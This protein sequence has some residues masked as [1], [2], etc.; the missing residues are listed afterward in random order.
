MSE[1]RSRSTG[2]AVLRKLEEPRLPAER[3]QETIQ[4]GPK[5]LG[6]IL[7]VLKET[8]LEHI[9]DLAQFREETGANGTEALRRRQGSGPVGVR[10]TPVGT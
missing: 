2:T 7:Y 3:V 10:H 8:R 1:I 5:I 4:N 6:Q 9:Q